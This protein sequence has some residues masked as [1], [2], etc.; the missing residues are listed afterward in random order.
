[1]IKW[2]RP[3]HQLYGKRSSYRDESYVMGDAQPFE[4]GSA[5]HDKSFPIT[6]HPSPVTV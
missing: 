2:F 3:S 1:M 6:H 5:G 4:R